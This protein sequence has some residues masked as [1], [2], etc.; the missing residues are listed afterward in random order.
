MNSKAF[1]GIGSGLSWLSWSLNTK[2]ILISGFSEDYSEME[3]CERISPTLPDV[4]RGCYNYQR[5][6]AGDWEW[7]P[8]HKDTFRKFECTKSILPS[9]VINSINQQL[10]IS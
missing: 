10:G 4:C 2:T 1:I 8:E 9:T 7:C 3:S 5:L 6:D